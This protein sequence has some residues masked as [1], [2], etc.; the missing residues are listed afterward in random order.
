M[1]NF[2]TSINLQRA[3]NITKKGTT[4]KEN[5]DNKKKLQEILKRRAKPKNKQPPLPP[6]PPQK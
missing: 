2:K 4:G 1:G 5:P 3:V 6:P